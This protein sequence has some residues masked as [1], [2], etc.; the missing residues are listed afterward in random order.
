MTRPMRPV[1]LFVGVFLLA[2]APA[3]AAAPQRLGEPHIVAGFDGS[4]QVLETAS[5]A[6]HR[7]IVVREATPSGAPRYRVLFRAADGRF[8]RFELPPP[9]DP[10]QLV[11]LAVLEDGDG[12]VAWDDGDR[13]AVQQWHADGG[14]ERPYVALAGVRPVRAAD[15]AAPNW[16]IGS[17]G[18]GTVAIVA[19]RPVRRG[20]RVVAAIRE[21]ASP[22]A[23]LPAFSPPIEVTDLA[24]ADAAVLPPVAEPGGA[25]TVRWEGGAA[26]RPAAATPFAAPVASTWETDPGFEP[27]GPEAVAVSSLSAQTLRRLP[28]GTSR[29]TL[30]GQEA[31]GG[32]V[33]IGPALRKLCLMG[34]TGCDEPHRFTWPGGE[35][36]LAVRVSAPAPSTTRQWYV[37]RPGRDGSFV[38]PRLVSLNPGLAP[39]WGGTPGRVDF[40]GIDTDGAPGAR[41]AGAR[42]FIVPFGSGPAIADRRRPRIGFA[43]RGAA[44][45]RAALLPAWCSETCELRIRA[46]LRAPGRRAGRWRPAA[47]LDAE[48]LYAVRMEPFQ[49]ADIRVRARTRAGTR[50]D[51]RVRARDRAGRTS[52]RRQTY[53]ARRL[54][55]GALVW[56]RGTARTC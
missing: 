25:V 27:T 35:E 55:D 39:L 44:T 43:D 13:I 49:S 42:V 9:R 37:A 2:A 15:P 18:A 23:P 26:R 29:V 1:A 16:A 34:A 17:D 3:S 52:V 33:G 30:V 12:F 14:V 21:A 36:R 7:A 46:R 50:L 41:R 48:G 47:A 28:A 19:L 38:A 24:V 22:L 5:D 8:R 31:T 11:R 51:L 45:A 32:A 6:A 10:I 54:A 4:A 20:V 40:A 53:R 56:C